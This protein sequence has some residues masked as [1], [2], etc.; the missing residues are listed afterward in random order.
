MPKF[1]VESNQIKENEIIVL[2]EDVNHIKNVLRKKI[3]NEL[4]ICDKETG[5]DYIC[6]IEE[7]NDNKI[8]CLIVDNIENTIQSNTIITIY[9]GLPKKDKMELIIQKSVELGVFNIVPTKMRRCVVKIDSNKEQ[10]KIERWQKISEV[11]SKQSGR[12]DIPRIENI[13]DIDSICEEIS[14]YDI[15][16]VPYEKEE[17]NTLKEQIEI[18]KKD[19]NKNSKL[20]IGILIGPEGGI[21]KE[22][23]DKLSINGAKI[24]TLGKRILRTETV[25]LNLLS[26]ITYELDD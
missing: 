21:E 23:I 17:K 5:K 25:A 9:Q 7:I 16:L 2:G 8:K 1:F 14:K 4:L 15:F 11:A 20:K 10:S 18:I 3:G 13:K 26:I 24:I 22:E 6:N 12:T 19:V